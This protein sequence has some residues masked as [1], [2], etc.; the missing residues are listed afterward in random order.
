MLAFWP[1]VLAPLLTALSPTD[2]VEVG[3]ESGKTTARLLG[4]AETIDATVHGIDPAP[5]FDV[6]AWQREHGLRFRFHR[7][8]SLVAL[9]AVAHFDA[10]LID[11][12]HNWYTVF[13]ELKLIE[14]LS[15]D[16]GHSFPLVLLHDVAWPYGRRDL[17]YDPDAIPAEHRQPYARRGISPT[18]SELLADGS[19]G[20]NAKL[21]NA[22]HEGGPKN[23]VLT[24]VDDFIAQSDQPIELVTIPAAFGLGILLPA[25]LAER[26]PEVARLVRAWAPAEIRRFIER[27][28][29]AR[30]AMMTGLG[31]APGS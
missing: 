1:D 2:I 12:D 19:G 30:I 15:A 14:S 25:R 18:A 20:F 29:L 10:V 26:R 23:G 13:H 6:H 21:C 28:E 22:L 8:P 16:R 24:A 7:L 4:L 9:S 11:G 27:L 5:G 31:R 17:Y 3:C